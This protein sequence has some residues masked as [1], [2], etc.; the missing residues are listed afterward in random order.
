MTEKAKTLIEKCPTFD[1]DICEMRA[2]EGN[3]GNW[4]SMSH[5]ARI[6]EQLCEENEKLT[7]WNKV[8]DGIL[9]KS[10]TIL[11]VVLVKVKGKNLKCD[12]GISTATFDSR[13]EKFKTKDK[14][15]E[16]IEWKYIN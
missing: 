10:T 14:F 4:V 7:K 2:V 16:I 3:D 11:T 12:L 13:I 8:E 9:P 5:F 1:H 15:V 6:V